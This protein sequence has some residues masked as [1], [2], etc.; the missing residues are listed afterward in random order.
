MPKVHKENYD[1]TWNSLFL[2]YTTLTAREYSELIETQRD[3][4][5]KELDALTLKDALEKINT[6]NGSLWK[7]KTTVNSNL[8]LK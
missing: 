3:E 7:L 8:E 5:E 1:K 2:K 4:S 6:K